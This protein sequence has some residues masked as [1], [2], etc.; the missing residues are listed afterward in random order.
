MAQLIREIGKSGVS[1]SAIGLGTWAMGGWMWGGHD[2][3]N[4]IKAIQA[5]FD[6]GI[7]LID[8]APA[9]GLG[10]AEEL[11]GKAIEGRR[12]QV[13]IATKCGMVWDTDKGNYFVDEH[14]KKIHRYLGA[15]S[16]RSELETSLKRLRT[17][18]V[19]LYITHWQDPTTPI[20]ETMGALLDLKKEGKI[21]SIGISNVNA[22]EMKQYLAAGQLDSIQECYNML[23]RQLEDE[24]VPLCVENNVAILSYSSMALG[25]LSGKIG[26]D[27][28]FEGDDLRRENPKFSVENRKRVAEF[29]KVLQP[30]ADAHN[31]QPGQI[32]IAWT[33]AQKGITFSLC[34]ARN[35]QQAAENAKAGEIVLGAVELAIIDKAISAHLG[36]VARA[37]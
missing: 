31:V 7:T 26:P 5:S 23:E 34:G 24:L 13:V 2:D 37:A 9:Y 17:D 4:S 10:R 16:V 29:M 11:V 21:R 3:A 15:E 22:D 32:V 18:Y 30:I 35:A 8:T 12:D 1:A 25:L 27:R 20:S 33:I 19:D 14:D 36:P 6:A 28:V